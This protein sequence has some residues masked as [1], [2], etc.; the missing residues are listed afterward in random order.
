MIF[1]ENLKP[2]LIEQMKKKTRRYRKVQ[3][4]KMFFSFYLPFWIVVYVIILE[5]KIRKLTFTQRSLM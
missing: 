2:Q 5:E 4:A 3:M 1:L